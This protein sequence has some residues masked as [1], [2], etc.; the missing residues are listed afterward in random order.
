MGFNTPG[1]YKTQVNEAW[2]WLLD[3]RADIAFV[4]EAQI[5]DAVR[6]EHAVVFAPAFDGSPWGSA[7]VGTTIEVREARPDP[8]LRWLN[9]LWGWV[10]TA[11]ANVDGRTVQL[12]SIHASARQL[13]V[14]DS[15]ADG[16]GPLHWPGQMWPAD[17]IFR[18]LKRLLRDQSFLVAGDLNMDAAMDKESWAVGGNTLF[19]DSLLQAGF[20]NC[21]SE[22]ER[23]FFAEGKKEYQLDY[24]FASHDVHRALRAALVVPY[25]DV[26]ALSDHAPVL[27]EFDFGKSN[28]E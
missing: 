12:A 24:V 5:P 28:A 6:E 17:L 13:K 8:T 16:E 27:T 2:A 10:V 14:L 11:T 3:Q 18:D 1:A 20:V 25:A 9:D 4:Q 21:S 7:V 15:P 22:R 26:E 23:T 19:F